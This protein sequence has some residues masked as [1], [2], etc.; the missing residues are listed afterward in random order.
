MS[1]V[2]KHVR[3]SLNGKLKTKY[4]DTSF[5]T[6]VDGRRMINF[7]EELDLNFEMI[8]IFIISHRT[9]ARLRPS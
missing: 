5:G 4:V 8:S 3:Q 7:F 6:L 9:G 2:P 1:K